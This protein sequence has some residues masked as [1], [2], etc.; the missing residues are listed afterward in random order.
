VVSWFST[1]S[2]A[3]RANPG[4]ENAGARSKDVNRGAIVREAGLGIHAGGRA[5]SAG[6]GL[7]SGGVVSGIA[8]VIASGDGKEDA[9]INKRL[10]GVVYSG[11]LTA[12]KGYVS[13]G[14]VGA[15]AGLGIGSNSVYTGNDTGVRARSVSVKD[16]NG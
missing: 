6:R 16:L 15:V 14:A 5:N 4:A 3:V 9:S 13:N 1:Y 11:G 10:G 12:T 2:S 7:I 8:V